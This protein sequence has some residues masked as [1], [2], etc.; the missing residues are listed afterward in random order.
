MPIRTHTDDQPTL[1][2]TSML[3]V[4]FMLLIFFLVGTKFA[5]MERDIQLHV[6]AVAENAALTEAPAKRVVNVYPDGQITLDREPVTL[7]QMRERLAAARR[8][9]A[10]LGV[11]VRGDGAADFQTVANVL[12]ECKRAGI[13][14][15]A[16]AVRLTDRAPR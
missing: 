4:T 9:Y 16:I 3:D 7:E 13:S 14:E 2:L 12:N 6:P 11:L 1:N 10:D 15:L 5:E 8:Q